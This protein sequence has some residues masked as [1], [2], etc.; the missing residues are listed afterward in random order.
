MFVFIC[1]L[2]FS[3]CFT[4]IPL[5]CELVSKVVYLQREQLT[6]AAKTGTPVRTSK[7]KE[8]HK[9]FNDSPIY[10]EKVEGSPNKIIL[11]VTAGQ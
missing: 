2:S 7:C 9:I 8:T 5:I 1:K 11:H 3:A 4:Q 10:A 6:P